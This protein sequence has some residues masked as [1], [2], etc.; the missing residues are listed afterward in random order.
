LPYEV[1]LTKAFDKL[2]SQVFI[3]LLAYVILLIGLAVFGSRLA[4]TLRNLF[5]VIPVLGVLAYVWLKQRQ[6]AKV[7]K[8]SGIDVSAWIVSDSARV[9]GV[10]GAKAGSALPKNVNVGVGL[11]RGTADIAGVVYGD[12]EAEKP[13]SSSFQVLAD[14][15]NQLNKSDQIKLIASA[16]RLLDKEPRPDA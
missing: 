9:T 5:Y 6:I 13:Q 14:I 8:E 2:T 15:F 16:Q 3:F 4:D 7:A 10:R 12:V 1:P 11:A